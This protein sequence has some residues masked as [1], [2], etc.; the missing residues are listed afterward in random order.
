MNSAHQST[1]GLS[2]ARWRTSSYGGGFNEC[3]EVAPNLPH[4]APV[5]DSTRPAG[6]AL[7]FGHNAWR[8]F[9]SD[10]A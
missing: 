4:L 1:P 7:T 5:R 6:P 8:F 3:V 10:L 2:G 9:V